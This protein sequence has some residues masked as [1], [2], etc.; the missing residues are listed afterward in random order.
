MRAD[1]Y[2]I[3]ADNTLRRE[4][5]MKLLTEWPADKPLAP[6]ADLGRMIGASI[7]ALAYVACGDLDS[8]ARQERIQT[9]S[10]TRSTHR[11]HRIVRLPD[12]RELRTAGCLLVL[13]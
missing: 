6:M 2:R 3:Q 10:G 4:R 8:L 7:S 11:G 5:L 1:N 12:G 9:V 13:P